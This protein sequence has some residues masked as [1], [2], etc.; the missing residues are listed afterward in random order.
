MTRREKMHPMTEKD[1][2][3]IDAI[4]TEAG[5]YAV[6]HGTATP[7]D[8]HKSRAAVADVHAR[9]AKLRSDNPHP[10][11]PHVHGLRHATR[12][13]SRGVTRAPATASCRRRADCAA[14]S[15]EPLDDELRALIATGAH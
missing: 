7:D 4:A 3:L 13:R 6:E 14:R 15:I 12:A 1:R 8:I 5:L 11:A 9:L 10:I 2:N